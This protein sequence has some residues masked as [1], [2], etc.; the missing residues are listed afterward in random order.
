MT[1]VRRFWFVWA[2][3]FVVV[4][5]QS[6]GVPRGAG[7]D[8]PAH[9]IRA[10][11]LVRGDVFGEPQGEDPASRL[12]DAPGWAGQPGPGCFA[13]RP[14]QAASCAT[15]TDSPAVSTAGSYPV[16]GHVL[17]GVATLLPGGAS[18]A[19]A[20]R[21]ADALIPTLLVAWA[22][23]RLA[24]SGER[25]AVAA[26][27]LALTPMALFSMAVVN[28]SGLVI[29]GAI[30]L[31][32]SGDALARGDPTASWLFAA[33]WAAVVLPR[34]DGLIWVAAIAVV[35]L[36]G[37][38]AR[39]STLWAIMK[40]RA[41]A[42]VLA[43]TALAVAWPVFV[44]PALIDAPAPY[45]GWELVREIIGQTGTHLREAIGVVGWLDTP[46]P[47]SMFLLWAGLLGL[48]AGVALVSGARRRVG[49]ASLAL[50]AAVVASWLLDFLQAPDAGLFWQGRYGLP[51]LVGVVIQLGLARSSSGR[52]R[53]D[54]M[55][56]LLGGTWI[57]WNLGFL[58]ALRRWGVGESGSMLPWD[59]ATGSTPLPLELIIVS[60]ALASALLMV[61]LWRDSNSSSARP[62][63]P[64]DLAA[65]VPDEA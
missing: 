46:I 31:W 41:R 16:F 7:P 32:I 65:S 52:G 12:F 63:S 13:F 3:L 11:A 20:S 55:G 19:W 38:S 6:L 29:G 9:L 23:T 64:A 21:L 43:S 17:P 54:S 40:I 1:M 14:G 5:M 25:V 60:H 48:L 8:E 47:T 56:A 61:K 51:L 62:N 15:S 2:L 53:S 58:Q 18:T 34:T 44:R 45:A 42:A 33:G 27:L 37:A 30:A 35:V 26:V 22:I 49:A 24:A 59:W 50:V 57:V 39:P 10:A 4:G 28:P 36:I